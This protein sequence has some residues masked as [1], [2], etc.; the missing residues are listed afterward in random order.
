MKVKFV[1]IY[2]II[3][4]YDYIFLFN[5]FVDVQKGFDGVYGFGNFPVN[6]FRTTFEVVS[7]V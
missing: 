2:R 1:K 6:L 5:L 7:I 3:I 4:S